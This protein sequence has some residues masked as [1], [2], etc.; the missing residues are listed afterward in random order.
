MPFLHLQLRTRCVLQHSDDKNGMSMA[1]PDHQHDKYSVTAQR[2]SIHIFS[3]TI[4][5][6]VVLAVVVIFIA[7]LISI[8]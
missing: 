1:R 8:C 7:V 2:L 4:G 6:V 3:S 5:V